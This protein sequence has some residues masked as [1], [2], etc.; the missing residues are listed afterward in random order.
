M[1]HQLAPARLKAGIG[2]CDCRAKL[3]GADLALDVADF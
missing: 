3:Q 1:W 2:L